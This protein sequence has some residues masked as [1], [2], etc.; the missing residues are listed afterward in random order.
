M[1]IQFALARKLRDRSDLQTSL[2]AQFLGNFE[3][4]LQTDDYIAY[5]RGIGGPKMVHAGCW[6][7][8]R[9]HFVD[10]VKL[11]RQDAASVHRVTLIDDLFAIDR[12]AREAQLDH[13][14]R[15]RL[16]QEKAPPLLDPIRKHAGLSMVTSP[17]EVTSNLVVSLRPSEVIRSAARAGKAKDVILPG[18][19]Q[20]VGGRFCP[21]ALPP[22][23][24]LSPVTLLTLFFA[25][26]E[27]IE[28]TV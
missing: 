1:P 16:H 3:G 2:P 17:G 22:P 7:H 12:E 6:S 24:S 20:V 5:E 15:H 8:A 23:G 9:R 19:Q 21:F 14:A 13:A 4:I 27:P 28:E 10:A 11:N 26:L 18:S 25:K